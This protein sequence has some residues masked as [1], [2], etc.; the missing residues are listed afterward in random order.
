VAP[1]CFDDDLCLDARTKP[2]EAQTLDAKLG[3]EA[4]RDTILPRLAGFD[5]RSCRC[6]ATIH[7]K[8]ALDM[9]SGPLSAEN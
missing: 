4:F 6:L 2:F 5:L 9:N 3:V 7:D 8:R 1:P